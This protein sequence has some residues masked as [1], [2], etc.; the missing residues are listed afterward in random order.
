MGADL[1]GSEF[2]PG[3]EVACIDGATPGRDGRGEKGGMIE[4]NAVGDGVC[5]RGGD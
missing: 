5:E 3:C 1:I 4:S 2:G